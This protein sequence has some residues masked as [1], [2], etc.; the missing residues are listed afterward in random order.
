MCV[1]VVW[2]VPV[3]RA[4]Q[5][6]SLRDKC[7]GVWGHRPRRQARHLRAAGPGSR[8]PGRRPRHAGHGPAFGRE[9]VVVAPL[10][11]ARSPKVTLAPVAGRASGVRSGL[12]V[13]SLPPLAGV[14]TVARPRV[15]GVS[16]HGWLWS[17]PGCPT[18]CF[19]AAQR[20]APIA[21]ASWT[22]RAAAGPRGRRGTARITSA[23]PTLRMAAP[24]M[25]GPERSPGYLTRLAMSPATTPAGSVCFLVA[26]RPL[27]RRTRLGF[28]GPSS[29][30][31]ATHE[32]SLQSRRLQHRR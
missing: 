8:F 13:S 1:A 15:D 11:A 19:S 26:Y 31:G 16:A 3:V 14:R 28:L 22:T 18:G 27:A 12:H 17:A 32:V 6:E 2:A 29:S 4:V 24:C 10:V 20:D 25:L 5:P 21:C 23:G 30:C 9:R 7:P